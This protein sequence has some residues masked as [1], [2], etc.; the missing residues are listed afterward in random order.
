MQKFSKN[1]RVREKVAKGWFTFL[2]QKYEA[3][4]DFEIA[5]DNLKAL[6]NDAFVDDEMIIHQLSDDHVAG[7]QEMDVD[8]GVEDDGLAEDD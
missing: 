2:R 3:Y 8:E 4:C 1:L 6:P 7:S 5:D